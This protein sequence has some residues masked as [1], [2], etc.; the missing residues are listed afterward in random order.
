M[1]YR[2]GTFRK[3]GGG[4][5]KL[6]IKIKTGAI[7]DKIRLWELNE[8]FAGV[9]KNHWSEIVILQGLGILGSAI[10]SGAN[11]CEKPVRYIL[12]GATYKR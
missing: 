3:K 6:T 8:V 4:H 7:G 12:T 5:N 10:A 9:S 2:V 11:L 1:M